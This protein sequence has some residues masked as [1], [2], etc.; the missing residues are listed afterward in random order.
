MYLTNIMKTMR[1]AKIEE[2][3]GGIFIQPVKDIDELQGIFK[4]KKKIPF[5][6]IR[7]AFGDYLARRHLSASR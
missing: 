6:K 7:E 1:K 3:E 5:K 2:K 4:T